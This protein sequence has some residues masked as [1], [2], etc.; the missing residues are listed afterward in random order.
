MI[1]TLLSRTIDLNTGSDA[2][3]SG[4]VGL[5]MSAAIQRSAVMQPAVEFR[6]DATYRQFS[7]N[8]C[9]CVCCLCMFACG[10]QPQRRVAIVG[11][12]AMPL[13][14]AERLATCRQPLDHVSALIQQGEC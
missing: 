10:Q 3:V 11:L 12:L 2:V 7:L 6:G 5:K 9:T 4:G 14:I 1:L 8:A 13:T